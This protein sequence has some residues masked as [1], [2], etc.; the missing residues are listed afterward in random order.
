MEPTNKTNGKAHDDDWSRQEEYVLHELR[1]IRSDFK[2]HIAYDASNFK[3][4]QT[5]ITELKTKIATWGAVIAGAAAIAQPVL[6]RVAEVLLG[7]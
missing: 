6:S 5:S 7:K 3:E 2:E 4:L 1:T